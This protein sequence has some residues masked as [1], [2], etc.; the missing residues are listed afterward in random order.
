[1]GKNTIGNLVPR[2][3]DAWFLTADDD[4]TATTG[5]SQQRASEPSLATY[6]S[7]EEV[8]HAGEDHGETEAVGGGYDVCIAH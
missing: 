8:A 1:L 2:A 7:M 6:L 3:S 5:D 4:S